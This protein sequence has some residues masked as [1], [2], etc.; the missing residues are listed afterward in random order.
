[1]KKVILTA[2]FLGC[3]VGLSMAQ[4][5]AITESKLYFDEKEYAKAKEKIDAAVEHEKTMS[6]PKAWARRGEVY[7]T[8]A[9]SQEAPVKALCDSAIDVAY[10][11]YK[12]AIALDKPNGSYVKEITP[13]L[14]VY[15][16]QFIN[17]G[18][19]EYKVKNYDKALTQYSKSI[20]IKPNDT[21]AYIYAT[22]AAV[23]KGDNQLMNTYSQ[24]LLSL[25]YSSVQM[26]ANLIYYAREIE[27]NNDK[28]L[29]FVQQG[30]AKYPNEVALITE[31]FNTYLALGK[32][33]LAKQS[34]EQAIAKNPN[35]SM[36]HFNLGVLT[37][38]VGPKESAPDHYKKAIEL[39]PKN[40]DATFNL[41]AFYYNQAVEQ[42]KEINKLSVKDYNA[43][44]KAMEEK[45]KGLINTGLPSL[46]TVYNAKK[47]AQLKKIL[48]D[49]YTKLKQFDKREALMK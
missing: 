23:A 4:N 35:N 18:V 39:D 13:K 21:T 46:E 43:K 37:E 31:E 5:G 30:R 7:E 24:K 48:I 47:D 11:S 25:N 2:G 22:Y 36:L 12:K 45:A 14:E 10:N 17:E 19:N 3:L 8:I 26:F 28:A 41:G 44:G 42:F 33:D 6:N 29:A 15:W 38:Q 49:C 20:E 27:K 1:M 40:M 32:N 16:S 9:F 34:L